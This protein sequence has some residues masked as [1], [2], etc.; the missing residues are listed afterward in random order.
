M[1][2]RIGWAAACFGAIMGFSR[3]AYGLLVP[4]M[5]ASL[6]GGLDAYGIIGAANLAGYFIGAL[7]ATRLAEL[8]HRARINTIA[9]CAMC[10]A[11]A[12]SGL[13]HELV[14][15]GVLR[16]LT[17]V[18]SGVALTLTLSLAV[19]GVSQTMRG[20]AAAV[21]W[22]GGTAGV[23]LVGAASIALPLAGSAWRYAWF[24]MATIGF[25]CALVYARYTRES[26]SRPIVA[27]DGAPIGL[28]SPQKYLLLAIGYGA[29]GF[30][31]ID[32]LT[33]FG[34]ALVR[35]HATSLG[36][37]VLMLGAA[38][39]V[40]ALAWGPLVDRFRSGLPIAIAAG[41]S[42]LGALLLS[43]DN[44]VLVLLGA[45]ALG[46]SFIGVP[47]M[48]GALAQQREPPQRYARAFA[49]ITSTLGIGQIIGPFVGGLVAARLGTSAALDVGAL[50]LAVAAVFC[51]AYRR[52]YERTTTN[53][54]AADAARGA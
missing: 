29:Y 10:L 6:G 23:A 27:D 52:P 13:A 15:L 36:I 54:L 9:L 4:A 25:S 43:L 22:S 48:I 35:T 44:A 39:T 1:W 51:G 3:L 21:I 19:A 46:F 16:F 50:G 38:G 14:A 11:I 20:L 45:L 34:A 37:A 24:A 47:A 7:A 30:G 33:F 31:Y 17:G 53:V 2:M 28:W 32:V 18:A 40:G 41:M 12:A 5:R 42:A 8:P 26:A 49:T